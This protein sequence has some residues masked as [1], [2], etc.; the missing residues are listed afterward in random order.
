MHRLPQRT[1]GGVSADE[2]VAARRRGCW[3]PASSCS[4]RAASRRRASRTSAAGRADRPLLLRVLQRQRG[5]LP[6]RLRPRHRR[7]VRRRRHRG[8]R[9]GRR[10]GAAAARG[11]RRLRRRARRR[12][13]QAARRVRRGG[14]GRP[15]G[16]RAHAHDAAPL[17]RAR[18]RH[19]APA[20]PGR[21]ARRGR[22]ARRAVA[23]R[24]ARARG[25]R[26]RQG[27]SSTSR[28][29]A[30]SSAAWRCTR[31]CW[32]RSRAADLRAL[33]R[34]SNR[35]PLPYHGSALPT[36]LRGQIAAKC[37]GGGRY[38]AAAWPSRNVA[39]PRVRARAREHT[40]ADSGVG[41]LEG[42]E[43]LRR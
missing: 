3:T 7:A 15:G 10:A 35:R 33:F 30:S 42:L 2:R 26:A 12:P 5:A 6:R 16:R 43:A 28:W 41:A 34:D 21:D 39:T 1:Y 23:R 19:R 40:R 4:A 32:A 27:A 18:R 13:A 25:H 38:L 20:R 14:G 31:R 8:R 37:R 29:S 36:E 24:A 9:G 22:P 11:D 17:H